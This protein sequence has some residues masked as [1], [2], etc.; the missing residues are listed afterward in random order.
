MAMA[1][2]AIILL[3]QEVRYLFTYIICGGRLRV[4]MM[5]STSSSLIPLSDAEHASFLDGFFNRDWQ[6]HDQFFVPYD[7]T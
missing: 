1:M 6:T 7:T 2:T 3:G 5:S 4:R